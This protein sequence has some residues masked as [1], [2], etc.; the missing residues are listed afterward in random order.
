MPMY[1]LIDAEALS[2]CLEEPSWI[3]VDCRFTLTDPPAGRSAWAAGHI[4]GARYADLDADLSSPIRPDSGRHPLP[5]PQHFAATLGRWG[6]TPHSTVI[7]YDAGNSAM[8]ASRL[9]WLLRWVG[10][11]RV[12]VLDGGLAEWQRRG[13]PLSTEP[14]SAED[15]GAYPLQLSDELWLDAAAVQQALEAGDCLIDA[16]APARFSGEVEP[17][18]PVAGHIPG[19]VNLP[20]EG[21]LDAAGCFLP[22]AVL[23]ERFLTALA[24]RGAERAIHSC[25]SGVTACH[26]L[27]AMEAAGLT[28]SRL[29]AGSWSEWIRDPNRPVTR[30]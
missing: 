14:V 27:L 13:L 11:G 10:H 29:Y 25:G 21:N 3:L 23:R 19:A 4:P 17:V 2:T 7:A 20:L 9:W 28:G 6:V 12:A 26:N 16:R 30:G 22:P 8:A 1:P 15:A 24:G 5:D 18:D